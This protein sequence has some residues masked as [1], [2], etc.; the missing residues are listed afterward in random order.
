MY[1]VVRANKSIGSLK[2]LAKAWQLRVAH[3][4]RWKETGLPL[5]SRFAGLRDLINGLIAFNIDGILKC[6]LSFPQWFGD[7]RTQGAETQRTAPPENTKQRFQH[8]ARNARKQ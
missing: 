8:K 4:K 3:N 1:S 6:V 5:C 2:F 7:L